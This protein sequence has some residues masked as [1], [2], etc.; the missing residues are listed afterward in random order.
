MGGMETG[1]SSRRPRWFTTRSFR[2]APMLVIAVSVADF[3]FGH[4]AAQIKSSKRFSGFVG[5]DGG[6]LIQPMIENASKQQ[7]TD[8]ILAMLVGVALLLFG[9][10]IMLRATSM[11]S[12]LAQ[13][14]MRNNLGF[15]P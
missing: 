3:C 8:S 7:T 6:G 13:R 4:E 11:R 10:P 5:K 14:I 9:S 12:R 15:Y 1:R 2:S